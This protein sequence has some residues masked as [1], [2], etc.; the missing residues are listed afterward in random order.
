RGAP[1]RPEVE[2]DDLALEVAPAQRPGIHPGRVPHERER[3]LADQGSLRVLGPRLLVLLSQR[4][5][6]CLLFPLLHN[7]ALAVDSADVWCRSPILPPPLRVL[8]DFQPEEVVRKRTVHRQPG[9]D[10]GTPV[11]WPHLTIRDFISDRALLHGEEPPR[12]DLLV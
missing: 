5:G 1:D 9:D 12:G 4:P 7:L 6:R 3:R 2:D 8:P 10:P 11:A